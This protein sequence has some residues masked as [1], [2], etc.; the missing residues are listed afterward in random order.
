MPGKDFGARLSKPSEHVE[1]SKMQRT[2]LNV[3]LAFVT[4]LA[5]LT[6]TPS[7]AEG[8]SCP[9]GYY[10]IGGGS[11]VGCAPIP[12]SGAQNLPPRIRWDD[13]SGALAMDPLSG[14]FAAVERKGSERQARRAALAECGEG[15]KVLMAYS[16]GCMALVWGAGT[17][18]YANGPDTATAEARALQE[19]SNEA[20]NQCSVS[21][22]GC[23]HAVRIR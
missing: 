10:P 7:D 13:R 17:S 14:R 2:R 5:C 16:N 9:P 21:Y 4:S 12:S 6:S 20:P 22:T 18:F 11:S 3:L 1:T 19:C 15:C 8:G 23:S